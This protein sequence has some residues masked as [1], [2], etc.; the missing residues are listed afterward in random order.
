MK[1]LCIS[2]SERKKK[3]S[4]ANVASCKVV[5][6]YRFNFTT[7]Y[8][9]TLFL[10]L[11]GVSEVGCIMKPTRL[12]YSMEGKVS[13]LDGTGPQRKNTT[14]LGHSFGRVE[15]I[16]VHTNYTPPPPP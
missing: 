10:W 4:S 1:Y 7:S 15:T 3:A 9:I 6:I 2:C 13:L 16:A 5:K 14:P 8:I 11:A 12:T